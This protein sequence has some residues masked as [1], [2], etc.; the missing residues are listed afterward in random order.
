MPAESTVDVNLGCGLG[1]AHSNQH[2]HRVFVS[3]YLGY[4]TNEAR[5]RY[6]RQLLKEHLAKRFGDY[7]LNILHGGSMCF[8][9]S[10]C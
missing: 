5:G 3:T 6:Y 4:G 1:T 9:I 7:I 10:A 8:G 2:K